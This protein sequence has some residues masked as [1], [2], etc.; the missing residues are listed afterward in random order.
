MA[1]VYILLLSNNKYY[2]G[3]TTN[4]EKRLN[5]HSSG[6]SGYTSKHLPVKLVFQKEYSSF[7]DA[8]KIENF[9]KKQKSRIYIEKL[10]NHI[11]SLPG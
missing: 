10:I 8:R 4:L 6:K 2:V 3:S 11:I 1:F 5:D 7:S 9:I